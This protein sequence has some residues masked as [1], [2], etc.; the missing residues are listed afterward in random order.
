M[1]NAGCFHSR[2]SGANQ[3]NRSRVIRVREGKE[4]TG[5]ERGRE[6]RDMEDRTK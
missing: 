3:V 4:E 1:V 5:G 2:Q 6:D